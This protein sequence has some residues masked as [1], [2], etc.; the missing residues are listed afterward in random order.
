MCNTKYPR[1]DGDVL[2]PG[3]VQRYS[4]GAGCV[5]PRECAVGGAC[6]RGSPPSPAAPPSPSTPPPPSPSTP[7]P[8]PYPQPQPSPSPSTPTHPLIPN[9]S[10][11]ALGTPLAPG[12]SSEVAVAVAAFTDRGQWW[13]CPLWEL[14]RTKGEC[15]HPLQ[16]KMNTG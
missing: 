6:C 10:Q 14:N 7:S 4:R 15:P 1:G 13:K 5:L 12:L 11:K 9:T 3:L 2:H 16:A 8:S